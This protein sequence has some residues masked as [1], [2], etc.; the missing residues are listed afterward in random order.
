M[1]KMLG[2]FIQRAKTPDRR[3]RGLHG[4]SKQRKTRKARKIIMMEGKEI[5]RNYPEIFWIEL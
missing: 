4:L 1:L 5:G 2:H 3:F